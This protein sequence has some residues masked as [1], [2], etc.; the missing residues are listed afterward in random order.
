MDEEQ[1]G[2]EARFG[3]YVEAL[4]EEIGHADRVEPLGDYCSG[5]LL[6]LKRKSVEP[7]AAAVAPDPR[8]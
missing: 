5:L 7:L 6:P 2:S 4:S 8:R 1:I 3:A